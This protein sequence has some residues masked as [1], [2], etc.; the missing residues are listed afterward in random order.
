MRVTA[1]VAAAMMVEAA[2]QQQVLIVV[3]LEEVFLIVIVIVF[4]FLSVHR[5]SPSHR[6]PARRERRDLGGGK[7]FSITTKPTK[8]KATESMRSQ[9]EATG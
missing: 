3:G 4:L 5:P 2:E 6:A 7:G 9:S 1:A 8:R